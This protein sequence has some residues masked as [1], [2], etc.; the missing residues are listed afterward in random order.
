[1][2]VDMAAFL[3]DIT[4]FLGENRENEQGQNLKEFLRVYDPN[5]YPNPSVTADVMV[6]WSENKLKDVYKDL[7]LLLIRRKNHPS[8]GWWALPGGFVDIRE[9][10]DAAAKRELEE[11]TGLTGIAM[12]QLS[13]WGN[14]N[15][16]PRTRIVTIAYVALLENKLQVQAG[17]DAEDAAWFDVSLKKII[18]N[19]ENERK[20]EVY[21]LTLTDPIT[22]T[23]VRAKVKYSYLHHSILK[24]EKYE[25][26]ETNNL[27]FDH[28]AFIVKGLLHVANRVKAL[29]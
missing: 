12:E 14:Y 16:D 26:L 29:Q 8:I 18:E 25:V 27:A 10:A 6:F 17:D 23:K 3:E 28:P 2:E 20:E 13:A 5:K 21:E 9:D 22:D 4:P 15:R 7:K 11:E 1:M 19:N 24:D